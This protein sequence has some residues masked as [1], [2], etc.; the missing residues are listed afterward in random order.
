[1]GG[2]HGGIRAWSACCGSRAAEHGEAFPLILG[3]VS[4]QSPG[5]GFHTPPR[6][7]PDEARTL[8][9]QARQEKRL[10]VVTCRDLLAPYKKHQCAKHEELCS[11]LGEHFGMTLSLQDF[12]ANISGTE[13]EPLYTVNPLNGIRLADD[14][15]LMIVNCGY[16]LA[17]PREDDEERLPFT[18]APSTIEFHLIEIAA[19]LACWQD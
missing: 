9:E 6:I 7:T 19:D 1:M 16:S 2:I 4:R 17:K 10:L 14:D 18:I 13:A 8:L 11:A 12:I 5:R 3:L 15:R